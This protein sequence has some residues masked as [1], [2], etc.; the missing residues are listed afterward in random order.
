MQPSIRIC[1]FDNMYTC[2]MEYIRICMY[3]FICVEW[4]TWIYCEV[5]VVT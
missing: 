2:C 1:S 4:H 5:Q 3:V